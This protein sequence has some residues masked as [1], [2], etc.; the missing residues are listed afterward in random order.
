M[1][2]TNNQVLQRDPKKIDLLREWARRAERVGY[3]LAKHRNTQTKILKRAKMDNSAIGAFV[4]VFGFVAL[5]PSIKNLIGNYVPLI[6]AV[7][8]AIFLFADAYMPSILED[9]NPQRF[10]DY[11]HYILKYA[12]DLDALAENT[13]L[14]LLE[15]NARADLLIDWARANLDDAIKEWPWLINVISPNPPTVQQHP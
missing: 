3:E 8:G 1:Q 4:L 14:P 11:A 10:G 6:I 15:W 7:I 2:S 13:A 5:V 9:P 12:R